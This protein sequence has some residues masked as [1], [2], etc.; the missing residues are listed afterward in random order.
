MAAITI[1]PI[2]TKDNRAL[3]QVIRAVLTEFNANRPGTAFEDES[4]KSMAEFYVDDGQAYF[5]AVDGTTIVGGAGIGKLANE[6]TGCELQKMYILPECR[7]KGVGAMLLKACLQ[8]A[9][10]VGYSFCY[11]ETFPSMKKAQQLYKKNGFRYIK[12]RLGNTCHSACDVFMRKE[13]D[14]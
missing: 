1:R 10:K 11:L 14:Q 2:Q 6:P 5:V 4:L 13:L 12:N 9:A 3:E 7:G 8:F